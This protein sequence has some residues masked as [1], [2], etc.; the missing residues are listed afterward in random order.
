MN[1]VPGVTMQVKL[2]VKEETLKLTDKCRNNFAC[3]SGGKSCLCEIEDSFDGRVLFVKVGNKVCD[4]KMSFGYS[5]VCNCP[6]R[7]ELYSRYK[8]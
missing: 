5:Y 3:L 4:Y 8:V 6:T 7:K 2:E 1:R